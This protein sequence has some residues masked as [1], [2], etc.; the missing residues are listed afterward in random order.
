M[1]WKNIRNFLASGLRLESVLG[2][3][4]QQ[5]SQ[6]IKSISFFIFELGQHLSWDIMVQKKFY[7]WSASIPKYENVFCKKYKIFFRVNFF[8]FFGLGAGK[9]ARLLQYSLLA[10]WELWMVLSKLVAEISITTALELLAT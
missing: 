3:L 4:N 10:T 7:S 9:C 8:C 6:S 2:R 1:F 5:S